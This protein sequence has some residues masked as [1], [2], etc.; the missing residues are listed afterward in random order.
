MFFF[1]APGYTLG[2]LNHLALAQSRL[3]LLQLLKRVAHILWG[4]SQSHC[5]AL[6]RLEVVPPGIAE[7]N[8][9]CSCTR[10]PPSRLRERAAASRAARTVSRCCSSA[11]A[12]LSACRCASA[13]CTSAAVAMASAALGSCTS[14]R[15]VGEGASTSSSDSSEVSPSSPGPHPPSSS[16]SSPSLSSHCF[17][18]SLVLSLALL[19]KCAASRP[20]GRGPCR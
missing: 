3:H 8:G 17:I 16:S 6:L 1:L 5:S 9:L 10:R 11:A 7:D 15:R 12:S 2:A 4:C 19:L 14:P 18:L 20:H 13:A